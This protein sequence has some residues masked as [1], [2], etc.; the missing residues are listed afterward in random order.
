MEK[1]KIPDLPEPSDQDKKLIAAN[2]T[3][4]GKILREGEGTARAATDILNKLAFRDEIIG[5]ELLNQIIKKELEFLSEKEITEIRKDWFESLSDEDWLAKQANALAGEYGWDKEKSEK[6]L[7]LFGDIL[8]FFQGLSFSEAPD[9]KRARQ[10]VGK[11]G[12]LAITRQLME[13]HGYNRDIIHDMEAL[14]SFWQKNFLKKREQEEKA[15]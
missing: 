15:D 4:V 13:E 14:I 11:R 9:E 8:V 12:L 6:L 5:D 1:D 7:K 3:E 10:T 2:M